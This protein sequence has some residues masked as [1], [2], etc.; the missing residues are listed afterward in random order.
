M[1]LTMLIGVIM[2]L[3]LIVWG[4]G[5]DKLGNFVDMQSL[6]IVFGGAVAATIAS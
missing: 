1:D 2:A 3:G 6:A 5:V 4:I